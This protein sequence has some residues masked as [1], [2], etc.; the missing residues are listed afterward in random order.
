M[1]HSDDDDDDD[2]SGPSTT[3]P[4]STPPPIPSCWCNDDGDNDCTINPDNICTECGGT[5]DPQAT[6]LSTSF[7][8]PP[9]AST[10]ITWVGQWV[11]QGGDVA[12]FCDSVK[13]ALCSSCCGLPEPNP[14]VSLS[15]ST[16][17]PCSCDDGKSCTIDTCAADGSCIFTPV[18]CNIDVTV[19]YSDYCG[20]FC[21][22]CG[23]T[24]DPE[25]NL[26]VGGDFTC[27]TYYY[28]QDSL[29]EG[30]ADFCNSIKTLSC[31]DGCCSGGDPA[32]N[33]YSDSDFSCGNI[34]SECG[35]TFDP[36]AYIDLGHVNMTCANMVGTQE[37]AFV[38]EG[39]DDFCN[40]IKGVSCLSDCCKDGDPTTDPTYG[41]LECIFRFGECFEK[42]PGCATTCSSNDADNIDPDSDETICD[43]IQKDDKFCNYDTYV[44]S[45][46]PECTSAAEELLTCVTKTCDV[47]GDRKS[48]NSDTSRASST[49]LGLFVWLIPMAYVVVGFCFL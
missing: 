17:T 12:E 41:A 3:P 43:S 13:I 27:G 24:F 15:P 26:P 9:L 30:N 1:C 25:R 35:G 11:F 6:M 19:P 36:Q 44:S 32:T 34:C 33:H 10:C 7:S 46:C 38:S 47:C 2:P 40:H 45:C 31:T 21:S 20:D 8:T 5:F 37:L 16:P 23:G 39:G 14:E 49:L 48:M 4:P 28:A 29:S 42:N 22:K 18:T